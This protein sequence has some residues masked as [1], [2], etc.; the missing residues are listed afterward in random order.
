[1]VIT[2]LRLHHGVDLACSVHANAIA[3]PDPVVEFVCGVY[4]LLSIRYCIIASAD[5]YST[6]VQCSECLWAMGGLMIVLATGL[7]QGW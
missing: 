2:C 7:I 3:G 6:T 4:S 5:V 1:M